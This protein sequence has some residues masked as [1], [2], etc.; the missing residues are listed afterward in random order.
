MREPLLW[1]ATGL[2]LV[3]L[4][5]ALAFWDPASVGGPD[6]CLVHRVTGIA[7]PGCGLTRA[8]AA[9]AQG[10]FAESVRWH[11]MFGLLA[12]EAALFWLAWGRA[13][14]RERTSCPPA[15][16]RATPETDGA[17]RSPQPPTAPLSPPSAERIAL[18]RIAPRAVIAT[19]ALL[20]LVWVVRFA[21]GTLP[22]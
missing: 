2:G 7:C 15:R 3:A 19:G 4:F 10:R 21:F 12:A 17:P 20:L 9:L 18:R 14:R 8:A 1:W 22:T 5:V 6:F 11:P 16:P 13:L